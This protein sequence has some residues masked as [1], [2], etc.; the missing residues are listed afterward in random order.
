MIK[1]TNY[2]FE[3]LNK[4]TIN[5]IKTQR[6][7]EKKLEL[8][9]IKNALSDKEAADIIRLAE[10][11]YAELDKYKDMNELRDAYLNGTISSLK[12][13]IT[14]IKKSN[15]NKDISL[16]TLYDV[17]EQIVQGKNLDQAIKIIAQKI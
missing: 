9:N 6:A 3:E 16:T 8:L 5:K 2:I 17:F 13:I 11:A 4:G 12:E 10:E 7:K 14:D 1:L 15:G